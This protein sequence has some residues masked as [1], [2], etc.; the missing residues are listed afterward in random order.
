MSTVAGKPIWPNFSTITWLNIN[1]YCGWVTNLAQ[2][3]YIY[4]VNMT[5]VGPGYWAIYKR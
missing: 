1:E 4:L 2:F 3:Q 5:F